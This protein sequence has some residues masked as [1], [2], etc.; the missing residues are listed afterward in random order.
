[1]YRENFFDYSIFGNWYTVLREFNIWQRKWCFAYLY[2]HHVYQTSFNASVFKNANTCKQ[3]EYIEEE[4]ARGWRCNGA[5]AALLVVVIPQGWIRGI[6]PFKLGRIDGRI[7][8]I[9]GISIKSKGGT[10][11]TLIPNDTACDLPNWIYI[12]SLCNTVSIWKQKGW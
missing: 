4:L 6:L 2:S 10:R 8:A 3:R 7:W 1:M 9:F 11:H 5:T 12:H